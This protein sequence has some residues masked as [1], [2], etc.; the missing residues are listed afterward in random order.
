MKDLFRNIANRHTS[1]IALIFGKQSATYQELDILSNKIAQLIIESGLAP[2]ECPFIGLYSSRTFYTI[3]MMLGIWKA[4]FAYVPMDPKLSTERI[5]YILDDC[6]LSVILT[7][8]DCNT[9]SAKYPHIQWITINESILKA[10]SPAPISVQSNAY[11]YVIY[12]SGTTGRPKG[13]PIT[14]AGLRNLIEARQQLIPPAENT[15]ETSLASIVFDYSIWEIFCPM[16]TRMPS[17]ASASV[18]ALCARSEPET[19]K[20]LL[21]R[22][23]ARPLMEIPPIPEK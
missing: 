9:L 13:S 3:P 22:I 7:D 12:T 20:P 2:M 4:G 19:V 1:E 5:D 14:Q 15:L 21:L 16:M 23:L 11:A 8:T 10:V 18:S 17:A 6:K